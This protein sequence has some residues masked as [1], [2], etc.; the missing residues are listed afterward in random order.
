MMDSA[1]EEA[2]R[3][4]EQRYRTLLHAIAETVWTTDA[5]GQIIEDQPGWRAFTGQ[6]REEILAAGWLT[7]VHPDSREAA[8]SSWSTRWRRIRPTKPSGRC[9][10]G[11]A[12]TG[13]FRFAPLRCGAR[14]APSANGSVATSISRIA[15]SATRN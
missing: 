7:A 4:S 15:N 13:V 2:L 11:T 10:G 14:T 6:T 8:V 5:G 12:N 3:L 1:A 9:A